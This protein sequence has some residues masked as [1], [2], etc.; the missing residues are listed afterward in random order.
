MP[1]VKVIV[2]ILSLPLFIRN[3]DAH[4]N[5]ERPGSIGEKLQWEETEKC[6][7]G[8]GIVE[9]IISREIVKMGLRNCV[10]QQVQN[11]IQAVHV[12][13]ELAH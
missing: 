13:H 4:C 3:M 8:A 7:V 2:Q 6:Y 1:K 5:A 11:E 9:M 12:V 10:R